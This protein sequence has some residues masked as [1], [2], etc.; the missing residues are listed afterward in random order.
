MLILLRHPD[1]NGASM[2]RPG[3]PLFMLEATPFSG[4]SY[5]AIDTV[6]AVSC[7]SA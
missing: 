4:A 5:T 6:F 7:G 3:I 2:Q 1:K